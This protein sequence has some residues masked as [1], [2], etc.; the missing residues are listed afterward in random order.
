MLYMFCNPRAQNSFG[1]EK[2]ITISELSLRTG[3]INQSGAHLQGLTASNSDH[4]VSVCVTSVLVTC[5]VW[6]PGYPAARND[7][8]RHE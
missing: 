7:L 2:L 1:T 3:R 5:T 8:T 6:L 4:A